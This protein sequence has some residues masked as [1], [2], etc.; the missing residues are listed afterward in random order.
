MTITPVVDAAGVATATVKPTSDSQTWTVTQVSV[1][2]ATAPVGATCDV[3]KN[4]Y[5]VSPAIPTGD[6]VAGDPPVILQSYDV[7]T[8]TWAGCTPGD[9]AR[10]LVFFDDGAAV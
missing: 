6:T 8:V 3:R 5:L 9:V 7:L 2:L 10:V 1:E 4:G